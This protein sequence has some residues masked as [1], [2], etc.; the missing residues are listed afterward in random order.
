MPC[1][2][3]TQI[4]AQVMA[5]PLGIIWSPSAIEQLDLLH[6]FIQEQSEQNADM[7]VFEILDATESLSTLPY[8]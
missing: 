3:E 7:V 2:G 1:G 6:A 4:P 5:T 8:R